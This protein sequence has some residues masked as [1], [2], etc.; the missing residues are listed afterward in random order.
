MISTARILILAF[1][2]MALLSACG[3]GGG[4]GNTATINITGDWSVSYA[5]DQCLD[6]S[7]KGVARFYRAANDST[8]IGNPS[9]IEINSYRCPPNVTNSLAYWTLLGNHPAVMTR[10]ELTEMLGE[11]FSMD[12]TVVMF[13]KNFISWHVQYSSDCSGNNNL[14]CGIYELTPNP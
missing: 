11:L 13:T 7:H 4:G 14:D 5:A 3:G 12:I 10:S 2:A 6:Y 8:Q 9:R 1:I